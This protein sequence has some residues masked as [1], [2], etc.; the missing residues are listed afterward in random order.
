MKAH[1]KGTKYSPVLRTSD[2]YKDLLSFNNL[3]IIIGI[4]GMGIMVSTYLNTDNWNTVTDQICFY[5]R[6][7]ELI[8]LE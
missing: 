1:C 4:L 3:V 2:L 6:P 5:S 8:I 7:V